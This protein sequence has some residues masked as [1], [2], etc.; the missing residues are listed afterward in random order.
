MMFRRL[1][2]SF[3]QMPINAKLVSIITGISLA[4]LVIGATLIFI[5]RVGVLLDSAYHRMGLIADMSVDYSYPPMHFDQADGCRKT[6]LPK[7]G[8][9][10]SSCS[11]I[12]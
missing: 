8:T 7:P 2:Q 3:R 4:A 10:N 9:R 12:R 6:C 1:Q 5:I 11:L